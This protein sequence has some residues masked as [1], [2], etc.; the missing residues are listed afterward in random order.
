MTGYYSEKLS[1]L[2]LRRCY[3]IA[4]PRVR[5]YFEAEI[6]YA[7][8]RM[9]PDGR[10][11]DLGCGYGRTLPDLLEKAREAIGIDTAEE[12]LQ[13]AQE[14][15]APATGWRLAAMDAA[16]LGFR[17][18][19]FDA[20]VCIQNGISA[21]KA[22]RRTLLKEALRVTRP[23]GVALFST[24]AERF[25][26]DRLHWFRLQADEGLLG[27]IDEAAT[28]NGVI[29]CRDGFRADTLRPA[30]F[31]ALFAGLGAKT[32][33]IEVDGSSLFCVLHPE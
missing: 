20:V 31:E 30:D 21:F 16:A 8:R 27:E 25:W 23:G 15:L 14:T 1:A 6:A 24:Y 10:V 26:E 22:D 32:E 4:P 5:Q 2:R 28:G 13:L 19:V 3:E 29:V 7:V 12:S 9:P 33:I 17:D 11:L 18:A